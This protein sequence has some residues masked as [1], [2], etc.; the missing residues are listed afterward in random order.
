MPRVT[1]GV[2]FRSP[3]EGMP[4][5][6]V[7]GITRLA[8]PHAGRVRDRPCKKEGA[9]EMSDA[10]DRGPTA[11]TD[12]SWLLG[13]EGMRVVGPGGELGVV[14]VPLY[15]P[16]ARWDRPWALSVRGPDGMITVPIS[17]VVSVD[18]RARQI[19]LSATPVRPEG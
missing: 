15:G 11:P 10:G 5:W 12:R 8:G 7:L 2:R 13:C 17:S 1:A 6:P 16:S 18:D 9:G 19:V 14:L 3:G 4:A